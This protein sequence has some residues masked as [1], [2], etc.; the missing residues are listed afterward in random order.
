MREQDLDEFLAGVAAQPPAA[1]P[2][3][4]DRVLADALAVQDQQ[5]KARVVR[6][7]RQSGPKAGFFARFAAACGGPPL[8]VGVCSAALAGLAIGYLDPTTA[9]V[10]TGTPDDIGAE[11]SG[12]VPTL[13]FLTTEG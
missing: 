3:L 1:S 9:A 7:I 11:M 8:L 10:L 6:P 5:A 12:L 2:A 4:I 13:D